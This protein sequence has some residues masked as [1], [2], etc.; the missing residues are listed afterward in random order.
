MPLKWK[1]NVVDEL[2]A[3][4]YNTSKIRKEQLFS[5]STL[6]KLRKKEGVSWNNLQDICKYLDCDISD[7]LCY[8]KDD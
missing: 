1:V 3:K 6:T 7:I 8:E 5:E 2:V 4:G